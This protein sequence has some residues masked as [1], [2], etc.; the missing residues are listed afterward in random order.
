MAA[1]FLDIEKAFDTTWQL[2]LL[3]KLSKLKKSI[4]VSI[5]LAL[6]FLRENLESLSKVKY[7][8][9]GI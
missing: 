5:L 6:F 9:Q 7:L 1:V 2:G 4:S 8:R 3:R